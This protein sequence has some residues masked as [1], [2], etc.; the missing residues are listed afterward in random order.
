MGISLLLFLLAHK[1][2]YIVVTTQM[3]LQY[4]HEDR[5]LKV[6]EFLEQLESP[7]GA[8]IIVVVVQASGNKPAKSR[9]LQF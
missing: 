2:P 5:R 8:C 9:V 3:V 1:I 7:E 6:A 4:L